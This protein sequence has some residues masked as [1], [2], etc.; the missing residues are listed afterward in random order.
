MT[1]GGTAKT[2]GTRFLPETIH[3]CPMEQEHTVPLRDENILLTVAVMLIKAICIFPQL[4]AVF[5]E[6]FK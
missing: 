4:L 6:N 5:Y 1:P 3:Q 2:W